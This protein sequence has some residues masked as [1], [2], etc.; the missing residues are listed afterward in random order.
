MAMAFPSL[1][2]EVTTACI[3]TAAMFQNK[4]WNIHWFCRANEN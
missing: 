4:S 2:I 1:S 3:Q